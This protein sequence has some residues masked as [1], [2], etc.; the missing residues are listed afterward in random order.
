MS[1]SVRY[2]P[3][4]DQTRREQY[5]FYVKINYRMFPEMEEEF[6]AADYP[7]EYTI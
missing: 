5:E 6:N 1:Y 3:F 7:E 2:G 4:N